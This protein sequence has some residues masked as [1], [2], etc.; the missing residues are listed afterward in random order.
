MGR[1]IVHIAL[2]VC[3]AVTGCRAAEEKPLVPDF[4]GTVAQPHTSYVA[5]SEPASTVPGKGVDLIQDILFRAERDGWTLVDPAAHTS[6]DK[7]RRGGLGLVFAAL[8]AANRPGVD[9]VFSQLKAMDRLAD[10]TA[11]SAIIVSSLD[12]AK[13]AAQ[14]GQVA[15]MLLLEGADALQGSLDRI[16]ELRSRGLTVVGLASPRGNIFCEAAAAPRTP[17]GLTDAGRDLVRALVEAG[18]AVDLTH[19]SP[20]AFWEVLSTAGAPVLV[21]HTAAAA[22]R[23]HPRNLDDVQILALAAAGGLAG[24]VLNPE[25]IKPGTEG[26]GASVEDVYVHLERWRALGAVSSVGLGTDYGGI[27][28]PVG[29]EDASRLPVLEEFMRARGWT[30]QEVRGVMGAN[31]WHV[32]GTCLAGARSEAPPEALRAIATECDSVIGESVGSPGSA[33]NGFILEQGV[34]LPPSSK[35][36]FRLTD[37]ASEPVRLELFSEAQ[38]IW[39]VE[40]Q[41]VD[42]RPLTT[43]VVQL[44]DR[45]RGEVALPKGRGLAR[46]FVSPTRRS[47]L[48]EAV[49]WGRAVLPPR[50]SK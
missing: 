43:R 48:K 50:N 20:A 31:A 36:R 5:Q 39:Q 35:Q 38:G 2:V 15:L 25:L 44:D 26:A 45:G 19:A 29:L 46:I 42:G 24:L 49:V 47:I 10:A 16:P 14:R 34:E 37:M 8:P 13:T 28:P 41:N 32:L 12:Q 23:S 40:A 3:L 21:T 4:V 27:R 11:G 1:L 6:V 18:V 30:D 7:L 22:I 9:T 17:S 33:C